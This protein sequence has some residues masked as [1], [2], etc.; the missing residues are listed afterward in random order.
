MTDGLAVIVVNYDSAD[1]LRDHLTAVQRDLISA[2]DP[3]LNQ[4]Q[5]IV[6]DNWSTPTARAQITALASEHHWTLLPQQDNLGFGLGTNRGVEAARAAGAT[7][8][9]LLNP[10]AHID[11]PSVRALLDAVDT[12]P[13]TLAAPVITRPDGTLWSDGHDLYLAD[14]TTRAT[15]R[16]DPQLPDDAVAEWF[17]GACLMLTAH[18][19]DAVGGFGDD[20]FLYWEDVELSWRTTRVGGTLRLIRDAHAVHDEGGTHR[21]ADRQGHSPTFTYYNVRNRLLF[22]ARNLDRSTRRRWIRTAPAAAWQVLSWSGRRTALRSPQLVRAALRGTYDG[23]AVARRTPLPPSNSSRPLRVLASF[24]QP[25]PTTNPYIVM[26]KECLE[27]HPQI[28]LDTFTWR[29]A[30]TGDYD[31]FHAHWPEILVSGHTPLKALIRQ[32]LFA[33]MLTRM[34]ARRTAIVRT[35]HNIDLPQGISWRE[36]ALLRRF[37]RRTDLRIVLNPHTPAPEPTRTIPHGHYRDWFAHYPDAAPQPGRVAYLGLIRRYK[38]VD[39]LI[40][41]FI[42]TPTD[43]PARSLF[44]GGKP[45]STELAQDMEELAARDP[46]VELALTFLPEA[47]LVDAVRSAALLV[48]PAPDMHNSGTVLMALSL[49]RPV[50]IPDN[51][52]NR[53]LAAEVGPGWIHTFTGTL[54]SDDIE[55][56]LRDCTLQDTHPRLDGRDWSTTAHAHLQAYRAA[57][58]L[59]RAATAPIRTPHLSDPE[60]HPG[61]AAQGSVTASRRG[62]EER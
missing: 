22:A 21:H 1:L 33:A 41:A 43:S 40:R 48:Q 16:R 39:T 56:A 38:A 61:R 12:D 2:T 17:T 36:R 18:L 6:V 46:R 50:L 13:M 49:D 51:A 28:H 9:L 44:I 20:Y 45:S 60:Q 24:P 27:A 5:I 42:Q 62:M 19:W 26:L 59:P 37:E 25:R 53:D 35:V 47:D 55:R 8:F 23:I 7:R 30:L 10:D 54:T 31:L 11:A 4:A 3:R 57:F 29:R 58:A 15:R 52:V 32:A 34:R 14:G